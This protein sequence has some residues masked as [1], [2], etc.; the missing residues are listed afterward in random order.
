MVADVSFNGRTDLIVNGKVV[1]SQYF[2][3]PNEATIGDAN[4]S[5]LGITNMQLP[6]TGSVQLR[7]N[8]SYLMTDPGGRA[9]PIPSLTR[10]LSIYK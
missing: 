10:T 9:V 8:V 3:I 2:G 6:T 1:Q 5:W 7:M 4:F